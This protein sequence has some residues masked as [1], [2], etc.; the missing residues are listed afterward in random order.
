MTPA[1]IVISQISFIMLVLKYSKHESKKGK[2]RNSG[3]SLSLREK[4]N[5]LGFSP[6][7]NHGIIAAQGFQIC[8]KFA[9]AIAIVSQGKSRVNNEM[10]TLVGI[11][12]Y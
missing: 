1:D 4:I 6:K 10:Y 9:I 3:R 2:R 8:K 12:I 7:F 11:N 5:F